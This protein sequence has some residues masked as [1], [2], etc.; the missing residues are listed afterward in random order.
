M[1][2]PRGSMPIVAEFSAYFVAARRREIA[3]NGRQRKMS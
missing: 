2:E 1:L 3:T